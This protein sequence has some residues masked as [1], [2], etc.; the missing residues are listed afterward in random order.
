MARGRAQRAVARIAGDGGTGFSVEC[1]MPTYF[2]G[3]AWSLFS[4]LPF[5]LTPTTTA[6]RLPC[7]LGDWVVAP[8]PASTLYH[9]TF[10]EKDLI[11]YHDNWVLNSNL[12]K[13][14]DSI[15]CSTFVKPQVRAPKLFSY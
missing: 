9:R 5:S 11:S 14:F 10:C 4:A 3:T 8:R 1:T 7:L 13:S 6:R 15:S 12:L 2:M